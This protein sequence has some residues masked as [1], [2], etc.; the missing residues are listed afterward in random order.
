[1]PLREAAPGPPQGWLRQAARRKASLQHDPADPSAAAGQPAVH[2]DCGPGPGP[3]HKMRMQ[4]AHY[5]FL[6]WKVK[7]YCFPLPHPAYFLPHC[8]APPLRDNVDRC[9]CTQRWDEKE[10]VVVV[11]GGGRRGQT[12]A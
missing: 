8:L 1:M 9:H 12:P 3:A 10:K 7:M 2:G 6:M 5:P 4:W 11:V